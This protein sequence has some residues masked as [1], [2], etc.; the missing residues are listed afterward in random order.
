LSALALVARAEGRVR[1]RALLALALLVAVV[2]GVTL[3]AVGGARRT[4]SS[5][6]RFLA[7]TATRDAI[8]QVADDDSAEAVVAALEGQPWVDGLA[9]TDTFLAHT[10]GTDL[11][12]I[13]ASPD[14]AYG[15]EVD[16]PL[17]VD[18]RLPDP[19]AEAEV[20]INE[21]MRDTY[22]L[23][24]GDD[25]EV[26]TLTPDEF[27]CLS[28]GTCLPEY[29][30]PRPTL[31]VVGV[32]RPVRAFS[33]QE[34]G[35]QAYATSVFDE[36][37]RGQ[38][39]RFQPEVR[40]RLA[41]GADDVD[42][43]EEAAVDAAPEAVVVSAEE[44]Y[45]PGPSD[46]VDV[47]GTALLVFAL[48]AG[49][50]GAVVAAQAVS[51]YVDAASAS[52]PTL[53]ELGMSRISRSLAIAAP[54]GLVGIAAAVVSVAVAVATS[55]LYPVSAAR[56]IE[57]DPGLRLDGTALVVGGLALVVVTFGWALLSAWAHL[58]PSRRRR[59]RRTWS[60]R[61]LLSPTPSS[62]PLA[63]GAG[64]ALGS[65]PERRAVPVRSALLGVALG[66][67]GL[68]ATSVVQ[69]SQDALIDDP[70]RW[71]WNWDTWTA[72]VDPTTAEDQVALIAAQDGVD[73]AAL[74]RTGAGVLDGEQVQVD[75]LQYDQGIDLT[76]LD[77]REPTADDEVALGEATRRQLGVGLGDTVTARNADD[78]RDLDLE[79]VGSVALPT[80]ITRD[81]GEG[82]V[83]TPA[84]W[85]QIRRSDGG[86]QVLLDY[87]DGADPDEVTQRLTDDLALTVE[88][89]FVP[90]RLES[91]DRDTTIT[92][93]LAGFFAVLVVL[94]LAHALLTSVRRRRSMFAV[95]RALGFTRGQVRRSVGW[96]SVILAVVGLAVGI[97][98]GILVGRLAW[99]QVIGRLG[100]LDDPTLPSLLLA[101][102]V[103]AGLLAALLVA[104]VPGW[105]AA[106]PHPGTSLRTE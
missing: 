106:R 74:Y 90:G 1:W 99:N 70:E 92:R 89:A 65:E 85:E 81:P 38:I 62:L 79:V 41:D 2:G 45:L 83:L 21:S 25:L 20:V 22:D 100:V 98:V 17:L 34:V 57:P 105:L 18:G 4:A 66:I 73:G 94:G 40:V 60:I 9:R 82:A 55:G 37:A 49:I 76:V 29:R 23:E 96:Q 59:P 93:W 26:Q 14:P 75:A 103:P 10:S 51:R 42:R 36:A 16:R 91:L 88:P 72:L 33:N 31:H 48:S 63:S 6:D 7:E 102:L 61:R 69:T 77:G 50:A 19:G 53:G 71:G 101:L 32:L 15:V 11:I 52:A 68:V 95:E 58:R 44:D 87:D 80:Y 27:D 35:P 28:A 43:L 104:L 97:P 5:L 67:V 13:E 86:L 64:L 47:L 3:S 46:S 78:T 56:Q 84:A 54:V 12:G 30:G 24:P 39:A 8:V